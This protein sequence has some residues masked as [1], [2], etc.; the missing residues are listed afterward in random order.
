MNYDLLPSIGTRF[1]QVGHSISYWQRVLTL[2]PAVATVDL[3][4]GLKP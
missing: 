2:I 1:A 4:I 3:S